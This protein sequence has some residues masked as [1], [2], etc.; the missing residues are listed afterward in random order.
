MRDM[1]V[2]KIFS[3]LLLS[4]FAMISCEQMSVDRHSDIRLPK[5]LKVENDFYKVPYQ[6]ET[7]DLSF[8][9]NSFWGV[10]FL[11]WAETVPTE[12]DTLRTV[13]TVGW[14]STPVIYGEGDADLKIKVQANDHT[15]KS[16]EGFIKVYTGDEN[17][18][19]LI[20][21]LQE[22]NPTYQGPS[23]K[24]MD[25][26]FDFTNNEMGWPTQAQ[27]VGEYVYTL[28]GTDYSFE[29]GQCNMA[30]A[31]FVIHTVGSS[32]GLPALED[33]KL[34]SV[35]VLVAKNNA[36]VRGALIST[37]KAG[38]EVASLNQEWPA[39]PNVEIV[40]DIAEPEYN[41][42]YYIVSTKSGLPVAGVT[43]HYEP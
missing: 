40:Y 29:F 34:T 38:V 31:N 35:T 15:R 27:S 4:L 24:P 13:T 14:M 9:T 37:D 39:Q 23:L 42:R 19:A 16:R 28:D 21:V 6:G 25:L 18:V 32:L 43:L 26:F 17:V 3:V 2:T 10:E 22:G 5:E 33:Y 20:S 7:L 11:G 8:S 12:G 36:K 30:A 41:T 1:K